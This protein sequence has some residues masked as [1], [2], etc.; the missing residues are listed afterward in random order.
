M[1]ED[2][3]LQALRGA[4]R[5]VPDFP[6]P[7]IVFKD[8][9]PL[10]G[11]HGLLRSAVDLLA[12][13][14]RAHRPERVVAVES[15][16]FIFGSLVADRLG[17]GFAP[18]RKPGKLPHRSVRIS[19]ALEYGEDSLEIHEDAVRPGERVLVVDDVLATG[20]TARA[21]A[22]LVRRIGGEVAAFAFLIELGFL[23][24]RG[25][26]GAGEVVALIRY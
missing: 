1:S 8:I 14:A 22:D 12:E 11:D 7:G 3:R 15:R 21:A 17:V 2:T 19:Y 18:V 5:D 4:V 10:L 9:T 16:G 23:G 6:K 25:R 13:A 24:G 26:I 20:G